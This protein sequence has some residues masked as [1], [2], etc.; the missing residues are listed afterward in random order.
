MGV[1]AAGYLGGKAA[2]KPGPTVEY[3][4]V[5]KGV[6]GASWDS[7]VAQGQN[8]ASDARLFIDGKEL[9]FPSDADKAK[10]KLPDKLVTPTPQ[11]GASD[12]SFCT[13][14]EILI[15]DSSIDLSRGSHTFRIV[16]RDG[17]FADMSFTTEQPS[18]TAVY[19]KDGTPPA[20]PDTKTLQATDH[21][22]TVVIHGSGL[23]MG[24]EVDWRPPGATDFETQSLAPGSPADGTELWVSLV[25]GLRV[26]T[27]GTIDVTTPK[28]FVATATVKVISAPPTQPNQPPAP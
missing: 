4:G 9:G 10:F 3:V 24:S 8:L 22:V 19:P 18:I 25:P 2:R 17:Q 21:A 12:S 11:L 20:G 15:V 1:S 27:T 6:T 28:G 16:N 26:D 14:L 13:R 23:G 7:L 5:K